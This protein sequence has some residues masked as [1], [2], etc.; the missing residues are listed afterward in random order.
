MAKCHQSK[1]LVNQTINV[2]LVNPN[3]RTMMNVHMV[4]TTVMLWDQGTFAEIHRCS[5]IGES[6]LTGSKQVI[7]Q[8][9]P[10]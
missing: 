9:S 7:G 5:Y 8:K 3:L 4:N 6:L 10:A 2:N 1:V